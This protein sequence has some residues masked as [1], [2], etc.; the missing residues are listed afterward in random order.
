MADAHKKPVPKYLVIWVIALRV[1]IITITCIF[2]HVKNPPSMTFWAI[3]R[4]PVL[5][6]FWTFPPEQNFKFLVYISSPYA[7]GI[8][9]LMLQHSSNECWIKL[10]IWKLCFCGKSFE[11]HQSGWHRV[12][13]S[14]HSPIQRLRL[15]NSCENLS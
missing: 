1:Q 11:I 7:Y 13:V 6:K 12:I 5:P 2:H 9:N 8:N 10:H 4:S 15:F 14:L 3:S